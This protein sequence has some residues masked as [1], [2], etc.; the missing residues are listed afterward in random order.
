M[1]RLRAIALGMSLTAAGWPCCSVTVDSKG[2]VFHGQA[3]IIIWD[4]ETKTEHFIRQARFATDAADIGFIAPT[5]T[6]PELG[7][8]KTEMYRALEDL[9]PESV[10]CSAGDMPAGDDA[11]AAAGGDVE[12]VQV[13]DVGA[14]RATTLR[15]TDARALATWM[16]ANRY[17]TSKSIE[18][19]T[20]FYIRKD[21]YLTAFKIR[22]G[23]DEE[24]KT[25]PV[26]MSF[27][28]ETPYNP[29]L[30][31]K[32]NIDDERKGSGLLLYFVS[33]GSYRNE[34]PETDHKLNAR[35][36]ER[37][38]DEALAGLKS[39]L[40]HEI[41]GLAAGWEVARYVD[42]DF[43]RQTSDDLYFSY[44]GPSR[45][46][47]TPARIAIDASAVLIIGGGLIWW[48]RRRINSI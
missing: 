30:V 40:D 15:A 28:T 18:E 41:K 42:Y 36:R 20:A 2:V 21:W 25:L 32:D 31:P 3:N 19:W 27:K 39:G 44:I 13:K 10:G 4:A 7:T 22:A 35:W 29:Y 14:Y 8:A 45:W 16:R 37:L 26:R 11:P 1:A 23:A 43:P 17:A 6:I 9:A 34:V 38:T 33:N 12:V 5:P 46:T 24:A 48:R 47:W